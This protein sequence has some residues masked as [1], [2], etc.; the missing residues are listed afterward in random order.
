MRMADMDE[1]VRRPHPAA[2]PAPPEVPS[3]GD[4]AW[5][6]IE[7]AL[8]DGE[9]LVIVSEK[10]FL[11][12]ARQANPGRALYFPPEIEE[13]KRFKDDPD[14]IKAV[15]RVKKTFGA[16]LVPSPKLSTSYPHTPTEAAP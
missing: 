16:W 15:H 6:V 9:Q 2:P 13:L 14:A 5:V 11:G 3:L 1:S 7:S 10:R 12:E 4:F 8:L